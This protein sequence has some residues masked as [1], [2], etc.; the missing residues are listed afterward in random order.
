LKKAGT[1]DAKIELAVCQQVFSLTT[2]Q[3]KIQLENKLFALLPSEKVEPVKQQV[4]RVG[5]LLT[6][7]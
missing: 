2:A 3:K 6:D 7:S 1:A 5:K 4:R